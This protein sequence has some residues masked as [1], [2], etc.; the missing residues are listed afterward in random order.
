MTRRRP[1]IEC[2]A[3]GSVLLKGANPL[4]WRTANADGLRSAEEGRDA[5]D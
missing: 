1:K 3:E 5:H 2:Q 4:P